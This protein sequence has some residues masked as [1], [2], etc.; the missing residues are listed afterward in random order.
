[1]KYAHRRYRSIDGIRHLVGL[2]PTIRPHLGD[3]NEDFQL[4]MARLE[5]ILLAMPSVREVEL[6]FRWSDGAIIDCVADVI[7][8]PEP[9]AI[10]PDA[11][12]AGGRAEP[13]GSRGGLRPCPT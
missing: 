6:S 12:P 4:R 11:R 9:A 3:S 8:V 10:E 5:T 7:L 2:R 13:R 1:M